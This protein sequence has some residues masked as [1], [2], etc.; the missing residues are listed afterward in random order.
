VRGVEGGWRREVRKRVDA[1][2][3]ARWR[4]GRIGRKGELKERLK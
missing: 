2:R 4:V 1:E 3:E